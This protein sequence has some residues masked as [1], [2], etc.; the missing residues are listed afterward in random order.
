MDKSQLVRSE[1]HVKRRGL[2]SEPLP[3]SH[4]ERAPGR[5]AIRQFEVRRLDCFGHEGPRNDYVSTF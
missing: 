4:G 5:V 1:F 2:L 3:V